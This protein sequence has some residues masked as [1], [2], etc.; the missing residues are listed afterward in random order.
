MAGKRKGKRG[1]SKSSDM[2][3]IGA[4]LLPTAAFL[5][6]P[7]TPPPQTPPGTGVGLSSTVFNSSM[8]GRMAAQPQPLSD[9]EPFSDPESS[10]YDYQQ[11]EEPGYSSVDFGT[12]QKDKRNTISNR[13][14][15]RIPSTGSLRRGREHDVDDFRGEGQGPGGTFYHE[16]ERTDINQND[17]DLYAVPNKPRLKGKTARDIGAGGGMVDETFVKSHGG[18]LQGS[19]MGTTRDVREAMQAVHDMP[20]FDV[21]EVTM[22]KVPGGHR[23]GSPIMHR[24]SRRGSTRQDNNMNNLSDGQAVSQPDKQ[25]R[26][27]QEW[28]EKNVVAGTSN[29][30]QP[31]EYNQTVS[32]EMLQANTQSLTN[33]ETV[34]SSTQSARVTVKERIVGIEMENHRL[35][36]TVQDQ[37]T[38][39]HSLRQVASAVKE[40]D[41]ESATSLLFRKQ[42]EEMK[43]ENEVLKQSVH[44]LNIELS[45][46]QAVN[47]ASRLASQSREFSGLPNRGPIPSWLINKKYLAPL[48]IAYDARLKEKDD[49]IR[50]YQEE[51]QSLK[52]RAEDI[53]KENQKLHMGQS[54]RGALS[55]TEWQ[56]LQEQAKLVLEENQVLMEQI[57]INQLKSK[58]MFNAHLQEVSRLTK[59][60]SVSESE[61]LEMERDQEATRLKFSELRHKHDALLLTTGS[62]VT[63]QDHINTIADI[64]RS[65]TEEKEQHFQ[66][67]ETFRNRIKAL[68]EERRSLAVRNTDFLAENK[69][70]HAEI[71]ALHKAVRRAQQKLMVFQSAM[72]QS[73]DK[74]M[75]TQEYLATVIKLAEK[76]AA[77]RDTYAKVA[78]EQQS[79]SKRAMNKMLARTVTVGKLEEKLK[80]YKMKAAAKLSTV[81]DRLK[82]QDESFNSQKQEYE[83]EIKH[84]RLVLQ[85]KDGVLLNMVHDKREVE[86]DLEH[87]WQAANSENLRM[88]DTMRKSLRKLREHSGLRDV[89]EDVDKQELLHLSSDEE[90]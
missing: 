41:T 53:V 78:K 18:E 66:E 61:K 75:T 9:D 54:G 25:T 24:G 58:E 48:F 27:V 12:C 44:K 36:D 83:R 57:E 51:L 38:E 31:P 59:K 6:V 7:R 65:L 63:V 2:A 88:K 76:T 82:E 11:M 23:H 8:V 14:P 55:M 22:R 84:L 67:T 60:L 28:L 45:Q 33:N 32:E 79:E 68:E 20:E 26:P 62:Q 30:K 81:A 71:K 10:L 37:E 46:K 39:L 69:R 77:E 90:H 80:L 86:S 16:L 73:E 70:L 29:S 15:A 34:F 1:R 49:V 74:E 85:D 3:H 35:R 13:A 72:E 19:M 64:K 5:A 56:Q 43:E 40:G 42:I 50:Q 87:M 4:A 21:D 17:V 47:D 52:R 89:V